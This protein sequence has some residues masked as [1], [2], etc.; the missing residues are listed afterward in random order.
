MALDIFKEDIKIRKNDYQ[1]KVDK[2]IEKN[3]KEENT[4]ISS[5]NL[6]DM[7]ESKKIN[8][9]AITV[10]IEENDLELLKAVSCF[11]KMSVGKTLNNIIKTVVKTSKDSLPDG[12]DI[13]EY[14]RKYDKENKLKNKNK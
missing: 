1:S 5:F 8:K 12:F 2:V 13:N 10:Y 6:F 11:K 3:I 7:E 4:E 14:A 9:L